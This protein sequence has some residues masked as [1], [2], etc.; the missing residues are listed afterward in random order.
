VSCPSDLPDPNNALHD[1]ISPMAP[2]KMVQ[3]VGRVL[4]AIVTG[5]GLLIFFAYA[6]IA[7]GWFGPM[8]HANWAP[9]DAAEA[10][11]LLDGRYAILLRHVMRVQIYSSNLKFLYGWNTGGSG[12][13]EIRLAPDGN[14]NLY[15]RGRGGPGWA[16]TVYDPNGVLLSHDISNP[17]I[18]HASDLPGVGGQPISVPDGSPWWWTLPFRGPM[19]GFGTAIVG[20]LMGIVLRYVAYTPEERAALRSKRAIKYARRRSL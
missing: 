11:Q 12:F 6:A 9:G 1:I 8:P 17:E 10:A 19:Y 15:G 3:L 2:R 18:K 7:A 16:H 13:D 20:V 4:V 5:S 14:L